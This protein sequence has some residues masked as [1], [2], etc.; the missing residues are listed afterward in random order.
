MYATVSWPKVPQAR[1]LGM[2]RSRLAAVDAM[3]VGEN[4]VVVRWECEG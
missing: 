2:R 3:G 4:I 1:A